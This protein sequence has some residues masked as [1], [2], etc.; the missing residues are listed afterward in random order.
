MIPFNY[1]HLYYF[2]TVAKEGSVTRAAGMLRIGQPALSTQIKLFENQIGVRL[3]IRE[4][5]RLELTE[6]GREILSYAEDI[7][8]TGRQ[9]MRSVSGGGVVKG[10]L[11][12]RLGLTAYVPKAIADRLIQFL[13]AIDAGMH[14]TVV[15]DRLDNL[16]PRLEQH[17]L[18]FVLTDEPAGFSFSKVEAHLLERVAI[19]LASSPELAKKYPRV[20]KDLNG[21]PMILPTSN[22]QIYSELQEYFA[23]NSIRPRVI[24]E[25]QDVELVRRMVIAG[26]GIAPMNLYTL[27]NAPGHEKLVVLNRT[28]LPLH[29]PI[30]LFTVPRKRPHPLLGTVLKKFRLMPQTR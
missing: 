11:H 20:P 9:M 1:H 17:E 6:A 19:A 25:V 10:E 3:F 16:L 29:R 24:A 5:K 22:S 4:G 30:Y 21:A 2:Y 18:D 15:E 27:K 8:E 13:Y 28:P 14:L 12:T 7:F 26:L 23:A